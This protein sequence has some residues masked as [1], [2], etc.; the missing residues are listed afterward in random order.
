MQ[1]QRSANGPGERPALAR[2]LNHFYDLVETEA[3]DIAALFGGQVSD[4]HRERV[5]DWWTEV[6]GGPSA[7]SDKR[8][9]YEHMLGRH[10]GLA[11]TPEQRLAFVTLLGRAAD[12][13][14]RRTP[15]SAPPSWATP[16][17]ERAWR[18]TTPSPM[19][20]S[21]GAHLSRAGDGL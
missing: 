8:G 14:E 6:M 10:R 3:P 11:I 7:Y 19:S 4:E 17:G 2:W 21:S 12:D 5:T 16:S 9:G 20:R 1:R 15:N 13:A 18:C